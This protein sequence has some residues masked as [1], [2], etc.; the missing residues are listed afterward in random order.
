M[1]GLNDF[2]DMPSIPDKIMKCA[3]RN[4]DFVMKNRREDVKK[5][6]A[7]VTLMREKRKKEGL[8]ALEEAIV[9]IKESNAPCVGFL[10]EQIII[11]VDGTGMQLM[12]EIMTNEFLVRNPDDF[13]ALILYIYIL[14]LIMVWL[15]FEYERIRYREGA[16]KELVRLRNEYVW[17]LPE[18]CRKVFDI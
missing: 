8:L 10:A 5:A 12:T 14:A 4:A 7:L 2:K 13:E 16:W 1:P 15:E 6:L 17:C 3:T 11:L 9:D 18:E